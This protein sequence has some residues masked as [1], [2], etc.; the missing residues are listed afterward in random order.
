MI[1]KCLLA[2]FCCCCDDDGCCC[3]STTSC[4]VPYGATMAVDASDKSRPLTTRKETIKTKM[5]N[6]FRFS[7]LS[8][9]ELVL[10]SLVLLVGIVVV[11]VVVAVAVPPR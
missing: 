2:C 4:A 5:S 9:V 8:S 6:H 7:G 1:L 11:V 3:C 10:V